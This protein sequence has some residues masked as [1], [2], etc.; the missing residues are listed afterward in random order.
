MRQISSLQNPFI[1]NILQLREKSRERKTQDLFII[2]G[3]REFNLAVSGGFSIQT[4]FYCPELLSA[5]EM[6]KVLGAPFISML[7]EV[8]R[9]VYNRIAFRND[10]EG[11]LALS[12]PR[13]Y[14][15]NELSLPANPL[16]LILESV[17][18]PGNLGAVLRTADAASLDAVIICDPL[19]DVYNPNTVRSSIG[20]IFTVP[21][22][23]SSTQETFAWLRS[24]G[25]SSY[26]TSLGAESFYHT[27]DLR[28]PTAFVMGTESTGLSELWLTKADHA[29]KIPM[30]GKIDS[31]NVS[32]SAAIVIFEARRQRN[33][34]S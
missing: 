11:I 4:V 26:A 24:K 19:T 7:F 17:E 22:A 18:K 2:E 15:L 32:V 27:V 30:S 25:I 1:K 34:R 8:S 23:V 14:G 3:V 20:C 5:E 31:M 16:I 9:Q 10:A 29:I 21:L 12:R 33:F 6:K 28:G 13:L